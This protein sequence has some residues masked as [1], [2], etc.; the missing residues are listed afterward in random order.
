[1]AR[2]N[3]KLKPKQKPKRNL[4]PLWLALAGLGLILMAVWALS[5]SNTGTKAN[6]E[7]KG[8]PR[9]KV[10]T[11]TID[12]G[13]VKLGTP[14]RDEIRVTNTGDQPLRFTEAPYIQVLEGC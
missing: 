4:L 14:V 2:Y 7:I 10:D 11:D 12:H 3:T 8:A 9:L 6:I 1:M 5:S 13:D